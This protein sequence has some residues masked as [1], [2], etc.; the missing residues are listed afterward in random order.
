MKR[1][2]QYVVTTDFFAATPTATTQATGYEATR[3]VD[4]NSTRPLVRAWRSTAITAQ[5]ITFAFGSAKEGTW[6]ALLNTNFAQVQ[7][8]VS[9]NGS[10]FT[11]IVSGSTTLTTRT[12]RQ[13]VTDPNGF[14]KLFLAAPYT[15]KTHGRIVIPAQTPLHNESYFSLGLATWGNTIVSLSR[16]LQVPVT[17]DYV[18]PQYR[19]EGSDWEEV[20]PAGIRYKTLAFRNRYPNDEE[21]EWHA[22]RLLP[23]GARILGYQNLHNDAQVDL[24]VRNRPVTISRQGKIQ[25]IDTGLRT[26]A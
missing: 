18:D 4:W 20:V 24:Y 1:G 16:H 6:V 19:A 17:E 5:T 12:V 11:D 15:G 14:S 9:S 2:F 23:T 8:A 25:E 3:L 7:L 26:L 10:T 13:D 21:E 22:L